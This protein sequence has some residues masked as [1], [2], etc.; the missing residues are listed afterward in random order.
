MGQM[1]LEEPDRPLPPDRELEKEL[2]DSAASEDEYRDS[3][4]F[5]ERMTRAIDEWQRR[6]EVDPVL[7]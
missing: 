5:A 1:R 6:M 2:Y 7:H 3:N 4:T